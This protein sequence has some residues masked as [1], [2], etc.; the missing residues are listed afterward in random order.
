M[1]ALSYRKKGHKSAATSMK[2]SVNKNEEEE[3]LKKRAKASVKSE[4]GN[5]KLKNAPMDKFQSQF[6]TRITRF[7]S[8]FDTRL[9]MIEDSLSRIEEMLVKQ[10]MIIPPNNQQPMFA[11]NTNI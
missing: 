9:A 10:G 2:T 11:N 3:L 4:G 8:Q 1:K 7:Q 5:K 6:D